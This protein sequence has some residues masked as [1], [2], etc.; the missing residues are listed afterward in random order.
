MKT[1]AAGQVADQHAE[2][3][4]FATPFDVPIA[5]PTVDLDIAFSGFRGIGRAGIVH[6]NQSQDGLS[7]VPL[8]QHGRLGA[9]DRLSRDIPGSVHP[10]CV[11]HEQSDAILARFALPDRFDRPWWTNQSRPEG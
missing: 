10:V 4:W 8:L 6:A 3:G 2:A 5:Q 1:T 7:S 9:L 11:A